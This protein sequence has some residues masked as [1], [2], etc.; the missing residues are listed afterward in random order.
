MANLAPR[1]QARVCLI[2]T[3]LTVVIA[4]MVLQVPAILN[5]RP[6]D[7][8]SFRNVSVRA[9]LD[10][11]TAI[12]KRKEHCSADPAL[13]SAIGRAKGQQVRIYRNATEF[14]IFTVGETEDEQHD[15]TIRMS[16]FARLRFGPSDEFE[17][18]LSPVVVMSGLTEEEARM[19]GELIEQLDDDGRNTTLLILAPH[20]GDMETPTDL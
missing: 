10:T 9:P 6:T 5:A 15:A 8:R 19:R 18:R 11:Q 16:K 1:K 13:L 7:E 4:P 3:T 17:G 12:E 20:G 2:M 14:A